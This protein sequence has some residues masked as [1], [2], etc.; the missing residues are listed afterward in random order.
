MLLMGGTTVLDA[1]EVEW[2]DDIGFITRFQLKNQFVGLEK[3]ILERMIPLPKE[4]PSK[5]MLWLD[6]V[7]PVTRSWLR[8]YFVRTDVVVSPD[9]FTEERFVYSYTDPGTGLETLQIFVVE[10]K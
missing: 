9:E 1:G 8:F 3:W 5:A 4:H 7:S 10:T 6:V 2:T